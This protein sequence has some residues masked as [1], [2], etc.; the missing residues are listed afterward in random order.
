[1]FF[2][3]NR[4][5]IIKELLCFVKNCWSRLWNRQFLTFLFFLLLSS[6]FW[7]L[8]SGYETIE[9]EFD[10]PVRLTGVPDNVVLTT[11]PPATVRVT[12][13]DR[14]L[15]LMSYRYFRKLGPIVI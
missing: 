10:I 1:M 11:E 7:F 4:M 5:R 12:L 6:V 14:G 15:T 3:H 8:Q 9:R 13:R 2:L